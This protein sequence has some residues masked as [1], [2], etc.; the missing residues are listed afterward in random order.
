MKI[1]K[2]IA[3]ILL[4]VFVA[5]SCTS[6][7]ENLNVNTKDPT[8]VSG[9]SLFAAVQKRIADQLITPNVNLNN[10]RLWSQYWQETTYTDESKDRKSTRLNSSHVAIS[11]AVF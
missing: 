1:M 11:Y 3:I 4:A 9:E 10:N 5:S 7:L 8:E 6:N 2:K